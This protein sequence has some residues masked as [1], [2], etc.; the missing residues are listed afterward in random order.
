V[1]QVD[2]FFR[3]TANK[4]NRADNL[5][6]FIL[7]GIDGGVIGF[8][9]LNAFSI[10]YADLPDRYARNRP[11]QGKIPAVFV[12]M[13][14]IDSRFQGQGHGTDLL[15]D[16]LAR[17]SAVEKSIGVAVVVLDVLDCGD[18]DA[19]KRRSA[20]YRSFGFAPLASQPLRMILPTATL[21]GLFD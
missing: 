6:T 5:R 2:N 9:A 14:G 17:I 20:F 18:I 10:D 3:K 16:C 19:V 8:Y 21:R 7:E 4:L 1:R 15:M 12:S 13:I 11:A